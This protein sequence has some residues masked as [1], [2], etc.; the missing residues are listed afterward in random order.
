MKATAQTL[1]PTTIIIAVTLRACMHHIIASR[2]R[3]M[4]VLVSIWATSLLGPP[5]LAHARLL[6]FQIRTS[7]MSPN[8]D[9]RQG[10]GDLINLLARAGV[11]RAPLD[12]AIGNS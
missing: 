6:K 2:R 12:R 11:Y 4:V 7:S 10:E 1:A 5:T 8:D 3:A 9:V